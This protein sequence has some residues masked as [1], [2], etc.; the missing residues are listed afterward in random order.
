M[1]TLRK[2]TEK[3]VCCHNYDSTYDGL[4]QHRQQKESVKHYRKKSNQR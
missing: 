1:K 3:K 4:Q 2:K